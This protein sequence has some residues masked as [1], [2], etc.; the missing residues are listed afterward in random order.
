MDVDSI[1]SRSSISTAEDATVS[2]AGAPGVLGLSTVRGP[3]DEL[4]VVAVGDV[5]LSTAP[6]LW[7]HLEGALD[8]ASCRTLIVDLRQVGFLGAAGATV[9]FRTAERA[10]VRH[11]R[12]CTVADSHVVLRVLQLTGVC[13]G[14]G[15]FPNVPTAR[16]GRSASGPAA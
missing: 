12:C 6:G 4:V 3:G 2:S 16:V 11:V 7:S 13:S 9:L 10:T 15:I 14:G 8:D 5:D 1:T